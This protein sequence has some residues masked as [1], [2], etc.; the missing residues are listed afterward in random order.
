MENEKDP[1]AAKQEFQK[2]TVDGDTY[3]TLLTDKFLNRKPYVVKNLG[4]VVSFIPGSI[5]KV[6]VKEGQFV[7]VGENLLVLE[8]MKMHNLL[9]APINGRVSKLHVAAGDKVANKQLLV[10][11]VAEELPAA[12]SVKKETKK[13]I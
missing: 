3:N 10:E 9:L 13:K 6:F 11:I 4:Q 1:K 8:A 12:K 2:F 7:T 5:I